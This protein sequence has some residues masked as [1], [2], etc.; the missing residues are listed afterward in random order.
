MSVSEFEVVFLEIYDVPASEVQNIQTGQLKSIL[1]RA[2]A[3]AFMF[4]V[5]T[6]EGRS[7]VEMCNLYNAVDHLVKTKK[8]YA[9]ASKIDLIERSVGQE[10]AS[11]DQDLYDKNLD[12]MNMRKPDLSAIRKSLS[13]TPNLY[14]KS[15]K[16]SGKMSESRRKDQFSDGDQGDSSATGGQVSGPHG[17]TGPTAD[18]PG[19][20]D[21][22]LAESPEYHIQLEAESPTTFYRN[23][24]TRSPQRGTRINHVSAK[25]ILIDAQEFCGIHDMTLLQIS[26]LYNSGNFIV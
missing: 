18:R 15:K 17:N 11:S 4:D 12:L 13:P 16:S 23:E 25:Q 26:S 21:T 19:G 8:K 9:I 22:H 3:V 5:S 6:P 24:M 10:K 14:D 7:F 1:A 2:Q 20:E